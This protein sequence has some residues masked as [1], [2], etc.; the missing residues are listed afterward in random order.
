M[1]NKKSLAA[2]VSALVLT[3]ATI[4]VPFVSEEPVKIGYE[5]KKEN[6]YVTTMQLDV[7]EELS[8]DIAEL[9]VNGTYVDKT[10][11]PVQN[12]LRSNPIVFSEPSNLEVKLY[13][14]GELIGTAKL[15]GG[16]VK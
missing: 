2:G 6:E 11:L 14:L 7:P 9:Y 12:Q 5:L 16:V 3:A 10:I 13:R 4:A 15:D 8:V 1:K